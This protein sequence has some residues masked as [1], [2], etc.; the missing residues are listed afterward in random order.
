M[1]RRQVE[2]PFQRWGRIIFRYRWAVVATWFFL[3][4]ILIPFAIH[5]P[6]LLKDNGF[7]PVGSSSQIGIQKLEESLGMSA[8]T[9]DIVM[10]STTGENLTTS[11][12]SKRI[13]EELS[14][15]HGTN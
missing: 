3:L 9:L 6:A 4:S 12:S 7:T 14:R 1:K 5:T 15:Y 11:L 8:A 2:K 13:S 10:E